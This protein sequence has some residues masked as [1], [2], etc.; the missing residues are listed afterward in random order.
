LQRRV[1]CATPT[2]RNLRNDDDVLLARRHLRNADNMQL[3]QRRR[4][5]PLA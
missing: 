4:A 5:K 1:T 3:A 2:T